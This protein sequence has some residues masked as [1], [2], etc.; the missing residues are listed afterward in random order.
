MAT[1][2]FMIQR[3][4]SELGDFGTEL[5]DVFTGTNELDEYDLSTGNV[6][7]SRISAIAD[8]TM[9]DLRLGQDYDL[10]SREGRIVLYG[11]YA[12][13]PLGTM[14]IVEGMGAGMF[15]EAE[16]GQFVRTAE[17]QHCHGQS[18]TVRYRSD[19]GFIR[20]HDEPKNLGNLPEIEEVPLLTLA[21]INGLWTLTTDSSTEM[22]VNTS[23]GTYLNRSERYQNLLHQ[24]SVLQARYEELCA[25]LNVGLYRIE[26]HTLRRVSRDTGRLV[27]VFNPREYDDNSYPTR[28]VPPIDKPNEDPSGVPSPLVGGWSW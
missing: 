7:V 15:T 2:R 24:I 17:I 4:R 13:L 23:E 9:T 8:G 3:L 25:Q 12:P 18:L 10:I 19:H 27:P 26:M 16:L 28:Q 1:T 11:D 14:L 5:R 22:S 20:Y 21:A 6:S